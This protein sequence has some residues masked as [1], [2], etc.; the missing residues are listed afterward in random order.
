MMKP[1]YEFKMQITVSPSGCFLTKGAF[2][3]MFSSRRYLL[4]LYLQQEGCHELNN[5]QEE[6]EKLGRHLRTWCLSCKV[7]YN[8]SE[9]QEVPIYTGG[10]FRIL[11][12]DP[13]SMRLQVR[14]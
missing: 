5:L 11:A 7:G 9:N 6:S 14:L 4:Q 13:E 12:S 1:P 3:F 10:D 8:K 2:T